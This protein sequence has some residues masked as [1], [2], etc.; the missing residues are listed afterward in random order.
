MCP[1]YSVFTGPTQEG[2]C[3]GRNYS[4][5]SWLKPHIAGGCTLAAT[6]AYKDLRTGNVSAHT[7]VTPAMAIL[8]KTGVEK[9]WDL[10]FGVLLFFFL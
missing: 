9:M 8:N 4:L 3:Q 6:V 1:S 7:E 5:K 10:V 2:S